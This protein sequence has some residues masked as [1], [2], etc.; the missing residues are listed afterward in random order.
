MTRRRGQLQE[1]TRFRV[2]RLLEENPEMSQRE[3][4]VAVGISTG[5]V[6]YLLSALI[7]RGLIKMGNF[8]A[9][10]DKRRYA[11]ILTPRGLSEKAAIT[12][13]FLARKHE[14]FESLKRE[15]SQLEAE[16]SG[17][18]ASEA[19]GLGG[20]GERM[21]SPSLLKRKEVEKPW[22]R[23]NLPSFFAAN[24]DE[25][26]GE[27]WFEHEGEPLDLLV[28]YLFTSEKLS[29][30]V[31]PSDEL[32]A[33]CGLPSGK[34]ECWLVLD[35]EP[36]AK[37]G[38]GT[39]EILTA[40]ELRAAALDGSLEDLVDWKPVS[41]GDFYYIP[42]GTVHAIGA[43]VTLVEVQQNADI[44]YRLFDY[45]RPR[46]LHLDKGVEAATAAPYPVR[47]GTKVDLNSAQQQLVAGPKFDLWIGNDWPS[48]GLSGGMA[49]VI[50]LTGA[51][52]VDGV[53]AE[54]GECL[55]C[56]PGTE[57]HVARDTQLLIAQVRC[58]N[59]DSND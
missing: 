50:P 56:S 55:L 43:G 54:A 57:L 42:A 1:D 47:L 46:E 17:G 6:H 30:Q 2:L 18:E 40:E 9:S 32:A 23:M 31:H 27:I 15:I 3:L 25:P 59:R 41:R 16:L 51:V 49:H 35:A 14:E 21:L 29:I 19:Q 53:N 44:T 33:V 45:G 34:D 5:S 20:E 24:S 48:Q 13:R 38:I 7:K 37:L 8:S 22:G 4:A 11:Y 12:G 58:A 36:G 10:T 52:T 26:I 39:R 28:K